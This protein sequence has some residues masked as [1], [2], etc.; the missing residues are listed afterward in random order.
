MEKLDIL[1]MAIMPRRL[2]LHLL[3]LQLQDEEEED[4]QVVVAA[5]LAPAAAGGAGKKKEIMATELVTFGL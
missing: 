5:A 2:Q 3:Q 4:D 1:K